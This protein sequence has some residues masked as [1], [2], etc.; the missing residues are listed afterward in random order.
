MGVGVGEE[1]VGFGFDSFFPLS[2]NSKANKEIK[3][4]GSSM[5]MEIRL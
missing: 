5:P 4:I 3:Y 1:V 2:L